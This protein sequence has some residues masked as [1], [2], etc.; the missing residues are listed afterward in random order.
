MATYYPFAETLPENTLDLLINGVQGNFPSKKEGIQ[1]TNHV[2]SFALGQWYNLQDDRPLLGKAED[3]TDEK[4]LDELKTL[5]AHYH[6]SLQAG[7]SEKGIPWQIL[8]PLIPKLAELLIKL[9]TK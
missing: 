5:K 8:I 9:F 1:I 3:I 7:E 2:L 6:P 4:F